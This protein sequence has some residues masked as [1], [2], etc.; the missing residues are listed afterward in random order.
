M[1]RTSGE[2]MAMV[3]RR[4]LVRELIAAGFESRGGTNHEVFVKG[5]AMTVVQ[6]TGKSKRASQSKSESRQ[7]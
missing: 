5:G 2:R 6:G 7:G 1:I 4:D 3:K